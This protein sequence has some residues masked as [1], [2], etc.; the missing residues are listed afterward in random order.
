MGKAIT[1]RQSEEFE[2]ESLT[3]LLNNYILKMSH[4]LSLLPVHIVFTAFCY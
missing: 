2:N 1:N 4:T 3:S